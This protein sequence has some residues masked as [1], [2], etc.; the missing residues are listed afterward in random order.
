MGI[1]FLKKTLPEQHYF[2]A[3]KA[4]LYVEEIAIEGDILLHKT[5]SSDFSHFAAHSFICQLWPGNKSYRG[6]QCGVT[7]FEI[8][9]IRQ[10][11]AEL[12]LFKVRP[13]TR[14]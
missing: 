3:Q 9:K 6:D 8:F 2:S 1:F 13:R 12:R 11:G 10:G 14:E 4:H 7:G 5:K